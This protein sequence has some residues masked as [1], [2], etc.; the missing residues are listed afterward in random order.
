MR[1]AGRVSVTASLVAGLVVGLASSPAPAQDAGKVKQL[2]DAGMSALEK[3]EYDAALAKFKELFQEDPNQGQ[4]LDLIRSTESRHFLSML[5]KGGEFELVARRLLDSGHVGMKARSQDQAAIESLVDAAIKDPSLEKRRTASREIMAN[6][7]AYAVPYLVRYLGSNDTDER[8]R[9]IFVLEDIGI[10]A[11]LPL[12]ETLNSSDAQVRQT[13]IVALRRLLDPRAYPV[14]E[15]IAA[16][17]DQPETVRRA[18]DNALKA[19]GTSVGRPNITPEEAF[20]EVA[21]MYYTK[22]PEVLRD[23]GTNYSL[24]KW[25]E[26]KLTFKDVPAF[27]YHLRLAE[28]ACAMAMKAD[29]KSSNARSMLSLVLA[30]QQVA[31][32]NAPAEFLAS[33]EGKAEAGRLA[34]ADAAIRSAGVPTLMKA[35][36][37]ALQHNDSTVAVAIIRSLPSFGAEVPLGADSP[38]VAALAYPDQTVQWNAALA[39]IR[40]SPAKA[41]PR[42]ELVVPLA[43][44]AVSLASIRQI[45]VIESDTKT[46]VQM[47]TELNAAGMHA[48]VSRSGADGLDRAQQASFDAVLVS[49]GLTDVMAQQVVNHLRRDFRTKAMPVLIVAPEAAVEGVKGLF[50]DQIAGVVSLPASANVYVPQVK[51]AAGTSPLN[52]RA[53]ALAMSEEA[54]GV[55][56][57]AAASPCFDF[58]RAQGALAGTLGTDKPDSLKL[59]ALAALRK[60]GGAPALQGLL[61]AVA[62]TTLSEDVRA[63]SARTAGTLLLGK[64]PSPKAFEVLVANMGD[65]SVAVRSACA[66][67]LG[68]SKLTDEQKAKVMEKASSL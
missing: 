41:F 38:L 58:S 15:W 56:A 36:A 63:D 37:L 61:D 23:L 64:A 57:E 50:G 8:V 33:D 24:W 44:D 49:S 6:H 18:A 65:A 47:Q 62:N 26:G 1:L 22:A 27:M 20:L 39:C 42:C 25:Q 34:L 68:G 10:E 13:A 45:L 16:S 54:C 53:R 9:A 55:L 30:A 11:V 46:A 3:G 66:G 31:L 40:L 21:R 4:I 2:Y 48:V 43:A 28:K 35:L 52:D 7:G 12:I 5:Q 32:A 29:P 19:F 59:K 14:L 60:F 67:A 17:K 51:E